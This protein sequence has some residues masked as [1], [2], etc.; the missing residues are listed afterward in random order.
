MP[1]L[2]LFSATVTLVRPA[3]SSFQT[4]APSP[5]AVFRLIVPLTSSRGPKLQRAPP[6]PVEL[7]PS[8]ATFMREMIPKL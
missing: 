7:L 3:T 6:S 5:P 1:A 8:S 4:P 2:V